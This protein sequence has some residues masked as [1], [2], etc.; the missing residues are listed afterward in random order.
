MSFSTEKTLARSPVRG[1]SM[2]LKSPARRNQTFVFGQYEETEQESDEDENQDQDQDE[3]QQRNRDQI[4]DLDAIESRFRLS[5]I[6]QNLKRELA[7]S[8]VK[9]ESPVRNTTLLFSFNKRKSFMS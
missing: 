5:K 8:H 4:K 3:D 6:A 9:K 1:R 2:R 7:Q